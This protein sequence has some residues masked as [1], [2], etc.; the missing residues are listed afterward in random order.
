MVRVSGLEEGVR[1]RGRE[2]RY[3]RIWR[4]EQE[5]AGKRG[6]GHIFTTYTHVSSTV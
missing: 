3:M 4:E 1:E 6:I 2:E 5:G